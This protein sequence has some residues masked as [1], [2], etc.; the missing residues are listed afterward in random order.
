M[1]SVS[2]RASTHSMSA[3]EQAGCNEGGGGATTVMTTTMMMMKINNN[4]NGA[5]RGSTHE[6]KAEA[7]GRQCDC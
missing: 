3:D 1:L 4:N 7:G 6:S 2:A 5:C